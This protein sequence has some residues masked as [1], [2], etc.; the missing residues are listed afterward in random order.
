MVPQIVL[1]SKDVLIPNQCGKGSAKRYYQRRTMIQYA[2]LATAGLAT[3]YKVDDPRARTAGLSLLFP[4]AGFVAVGTIPSILALVLTLASVPL[5]IFMWFGC[6]G[7]AF[8]ILLWVG[9]LLTATFLTRDTVLESAGAIV[10][11]ACV[12]GISYVTYQT[13][14]ANREAENKREERNAFLINAV[15]QNQADAHP[16]PAPGTR[17]ADERTLRFLQWMLEVGLAPMDDFSYHDVIDQF[18]TSAIRYQLYNCMYELAMFQ[19][20]YC[21]NF[22]GYLSKAQRN[23]I[24]KSMTKRVMKSVMVLS[25][26]AKHLLTNNSYWKWESLLGKFTLD[27]DPIREDN[28]VS[29]TPRS[30]KFH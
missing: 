29:L 21:P 20:N 5:I 17:E 18:Q 22:H 14:T 15:Q 2:F 8:P 10:T 25:M 13:Q 7:L 6:G 9:S 27:W 4:G 24:E 30:Q 19:N 23:A 1:T 28:I 3:F 16:P 12:L 11:A 26:E